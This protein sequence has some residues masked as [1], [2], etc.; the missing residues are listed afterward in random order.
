MCVVDQLLPVAGE[1]AERLARA[2]VPCVRLRH[3]ESALQRAIAAF[4]ARG[5][6]EGLSADTTVAEHIQTAVPVGR[7]RHLEPHFGRDD[8]PNDAR[9]RKVAAGRY[10]RRRFNPC[11]RLVIWRV[12][13]NAGSQPGTDR[14]RTPQRSRVP[15]RPEFAL[16]LRLGGNDAHDERGPRTDRHSYTPVSCRD[17]PVLATA[18]AAF[19]AT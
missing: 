5:F 15:E 3:D 19:G 1:R 18:A 9:V 16:A 2:I 17:G 12:E 14:N 8:G 4:Y 10:E 7:Q 13:A 6:V 11:R